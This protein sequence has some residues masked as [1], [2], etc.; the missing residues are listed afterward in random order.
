ME[1]EI[2]AVADPHFSQCGDPQV[3]G[4]NVI[5]CVE[6]PQVMEM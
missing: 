4:N 3:R 6:D 5:H 1:R 2:L